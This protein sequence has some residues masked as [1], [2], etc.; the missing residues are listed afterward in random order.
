M[1]INLKNVDLNLLV[2]FEA[3]YTSNNISRAAQQLGMSQSAVSNAL[4]RLRGLIDDQLFVR[5][6]RG[7]EPTGKAR[8]MIRPV[9]EAL[10][11]IGRQFGN[12]GNFDLTTYQRQFRIV[13]VDSLELTLMPGIVETLVEQAPGV[14]IECVQGTAK[15]AEDIRAGSIDLACF[16]FPINTTDIVA[17]PLGP[18]DIVVISRRNH[19]AIKKPLDL[20]T[21]KKLPHIALGLELRGMMN[22]EKSLV[23][24]HISRRIVYLAAKVWSIAPMVSRT[25]LIGMLPRK[26]V[27]E[28]SRD[29]EID[30]H[31]VPIQLPQEHTYLMWHVNSEHDAGHRWLR[32]SM[33]QAALSN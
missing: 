8:E 9:R 24:E 20:E 10:G 32:E 27:N 7:V 3:V 4:A 14:S 11:L 25:G 12:D 23:A 21:F 5:H 1:A 22:I 16:P 28:I 18:I 2:I 17:K 15:F 33:M 29:L 30:I 13:M 6:P 31:E 26:Y 19:P